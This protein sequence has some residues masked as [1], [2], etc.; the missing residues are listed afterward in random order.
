MSD[1][2]QLSTT[3]PWNPVHNMHTAEALATL[4][5]RV[6]P[7]PEVVIFIT[8][9]NSPLASYKI[10]LSLICLDC[11]FLRLRSMPLLPRGCVAC[12]GNCYTIIS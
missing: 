9:E 11:Y 12:R 10:Q 2:S 7:P 8:F 3:T 4:L 6:S 5:L 1:D